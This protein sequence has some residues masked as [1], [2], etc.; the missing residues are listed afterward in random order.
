MDQVLAVKANLET[1]NVVIVLFSCLS[2][3]HS[4]AHYIDLTCYFPLF[5]DH[6]VPPCEIS[7]QLFIFGVYSHLSE[8]S[9]STYFLSD[10]T[11]HLAAC[12]HYSIL[13]LVFVT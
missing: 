5:L 11:A 12:T 10:K 8:M 4:P 1:I 9:T 13:Q 7:F 2:A 3:S 6:C